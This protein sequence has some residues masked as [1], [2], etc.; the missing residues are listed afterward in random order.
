MLFLQ[1]RNRSLI[2]HS[3]FYTAADVIGGTIGRLTPEG[4]AIQLI[5]AK[6]LLRLSL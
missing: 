4:V 2:A 3:T 5:K 1:Y 6:C